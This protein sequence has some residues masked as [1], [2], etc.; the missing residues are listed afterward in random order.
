MTDTASVA[1]P[2]PPDLLRLAAPAALLLLGA[3]LRLLAYAGT[4]AAPSLPGFVEAM[5][6]WDCTWYADIARHGYQA[7]PETLNFGGPAGIANWAFFPLYP[8]LLALAGRIVPIAP[9]ALGM[10]L[11]PLLAL[12]ASYAAWPLFAGDRRAYVLFAAL[13]L[14]GPFS[15]YLAVPYS[16]SLF[17]LLTVLA[18]VRLERRDYVGAGLAGALLSATRTVGV[19]FAAAL[20]TEA[21]REMGRG[22]PRE[23]ARRPDV[24]LGLLLVPLGLGAFMAWLYLVTG[25]A[26]AFVHIQ[27]AWDRHAVNPVLALWTALTAPGGQVREARL[28]GL[29]ALAGLALAGVLAWRRQLPMALFPAL[30]IGVALTQ[31]V[32]SML[33]FVVAL[34]PLGI[35]LCQ[36]LARRRALFWASLVLFA[37]LDVV[38]SIGWMQQHGALM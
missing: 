10:V 22:A 9:E 14:A 21:L 37:G 17:V 28:L 30:A 13:L 19:L 31:G 36:L 12:A 3:G 26:L 1:R 23:L 5:C 24:L 8:L 20:L 34:A 6:V 29:A 33:R 16:E 25:D 32:E 7:Y 18:Y 15:F 38:F 11:S 4:H 27:R 35:V 2:A